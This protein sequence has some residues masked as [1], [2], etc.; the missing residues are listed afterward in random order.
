MREYKP[1]RALGLMSGT[2]LDGIDV[3]F[4]ES[5]GVRHIKTGAVRCFSYDPIFREKLKSCLGKLPDDPAV[6]DVDE[7]ITDRHVQAVKSMLKEQ[8]MEASDI[9]LLGFHGH[10]TLHR[11]QSRLTIQIGNPARLAK[12]TGIQVIGSFR[13]NDVAQG[14]EGAPL[15]PLFHHALCA[16]LDKP[17]A[18]LNIGGVANVTWIG[19]ERNS[20]IPNIIAFDTGPGN[21]LIDDW[22]SKTTGYS[23]DEGGRLAESGKVQENILND[24]LENPFFCRYPP[25]SLD[26]DDFVSAI[27]AVS[28]LSVED[29]AATLSALSVLSISKAQNFFPEIAKRWLVTGGGRHNNALMTMLNNHVVGVVEP[30]ESISLDGDAL[31]A[32]AFAYLAIR[33]FYGLPISFPE[34]TKVPRPMQGGVLFEN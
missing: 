6:A 19:R 28:K 23:M 11:P 25:K 1:L 34:T 2:S 22:V 3:A 24:L 32:Q 17:L 10:T 7:E 14:G 8:N 30:I 33:S 16:D 31:E 15:A 27:Q 18:V 9:D 5:D 26:R 13:S 21:A 29:G 20:D 4:I 12:E